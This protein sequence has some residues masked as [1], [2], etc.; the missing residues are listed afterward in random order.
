MAQRTLTDRLGQHSQRTGPLVGCSMALALLT[1]LVLGMIFYLR[2]D[3]YRTDVF[4]VP[5]VVQSVPTVPP[6]GT[7]RPGSAAAQ[8][9]PAAEPAA[10]PTPESSPEPAAAP[11]PP[12]VRFRIVGTGGENLNMREAA[13]TASRI[14]ARLPPGA[15]VDDAGEEATG[16]AGGAQVR[17]RK[18][19]GPG[20][21]VGWVPQQYLERAEG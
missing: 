2:L 13:N 18:V 7:A 8:G 4:G 1:C 12:V 14:L 10:K 15:V 21:Q 9:T 20:G 6:A 16:P 11:T 3:E 17:W 19:R 5:T